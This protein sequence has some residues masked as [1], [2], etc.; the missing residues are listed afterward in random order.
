MRTKEEQKSEV[1]ETTKDQE[2]PQETPSK[3]VYRLSKEE[4]NELLVRD[5][6]INLKMKELIIIKNEKSYFLRFLVE[7]SGLD[8]RKTRLSE[9]GE[10]LIE[11]EP[12]KQAVNTETKKEN[13]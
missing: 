10:E 3:K 11:V 7:K 9:N 12:P 4:R 8:I 5:S 1:K 2:K 13:K 6:M